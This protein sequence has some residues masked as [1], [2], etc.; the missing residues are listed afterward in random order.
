[1]DKKGCIYIV[2]T[3]IG[4]LGDITLRALDVLKNSSCIYAEDTRVTAKLLAA[5]NISKPLSRLDENTIEAR[6]AS[7]INKVAEG[8]VVSYCTDAGMPG[9]SDPAAKLITH[10][11][12]AGVDIEVLPG[13][14]AASLAY[15]Q[16]AQANP[17]FYFGGFLPRKQSAKIEALSTLSKLDASLVFY[18]SP[19]R[20][21]DTLK[22][23]AE[24]FPTRQITLC[25]ELTKLHEEIITNTAQNITQK[26][27]AREQI[28]GEIAFVVAPP[29]ASSKNNKQNT[30]FDAVIDAQTALPKIALILNNSGIRS[31]DAAKIIAEILDIPKRDAYEFIIN[32]QKE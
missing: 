21:I 11:R 1:V 12:D 8:E 28:K 2:P 16:S 3:P 15:V 29:S 24:V 19:H 7:V 25:R 18:E 23:V 26:L 5:Y 13:A 9:V 27:E 20:I 30:D 6:A 22:A 4:N 31:K 32:L 10:A 14:S 17:A